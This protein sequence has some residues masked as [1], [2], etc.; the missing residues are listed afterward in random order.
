MQHN[1]KKYLLDIA[2]SIETTLLIQICNLDQQ[3]QGICNAQN[4]IQ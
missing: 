2:T 1:I 4:E 3:I